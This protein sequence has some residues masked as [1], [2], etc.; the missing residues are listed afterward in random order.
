VVAG[1]SPVAGQSVEDVKKPEPI[2][3]EVFTLTGEFVRIAYNNEGWVTLGYRTAN[4]SKG[5]EWLLLETGMTLRKGNKNFDLTR[6]HISLQIPDGSTI[7]L[8]TQEAF[9]KANLRA[10]DRRASMVRDSINYFP[11]SVNNP[12]VLSF[13]ADPGTPGRSLAFDQVEL[14]WDRA[15]VGRLYFQIPG[16][17]GITTGQHYLNVKF[18]NS[19]LQV[20]FYIMTDEQEKEFRK[21]WKTMK[22]E[23]EAEYQQ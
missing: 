7:P 3:P 1:A 21:K 19:L 12:C 23:H 14:S 15:C 5:D 8:A 4:D 9:G 6:E 10:L 11:T 13:F 2:E 17:D 16:D 18:P 20:P 22:K